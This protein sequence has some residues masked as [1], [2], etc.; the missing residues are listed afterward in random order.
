MLASK[1]IGVALNFDRAEKKFFEELNQ[2]YAFFFEDDLIVNKFYIE[3]LEQ[4][5]QFALEDERIAYVSAYGDHRA[6]LDT[7]KKRQSEVI[8]MGH[9]WGFS[10]TQRQWLRQKDILDGYL[11]IVSKRPYRARDH[12]AI[13]QYFNSLG[14]SSPGSSQDA[15]KDV[16]SLVLGTVKLNTVACF[17]KN[18]GAVGLHS[19]QQFYD[20]QGFGDTIMLESKP[21]LQKPN[22]DTI[23]QL[24]ATQRRHARVSTSNDFQKLAESLFGG[25]PYNNFSPT[26]KEPDLQ[27]WNG[28]H[29]AL[30]QA[31]YKQKPKIIVDVGVWKG[32]STINLARSQNEVRSDG[33]VIAVDTFLGAA[34]HWDIKRQDVYDS[35]KFKNGRPSIYE[36]FMSNVVLNRLQSQILPLS[37]TSENAAFILKRQGINPDLVHLDAAQEYD[38][39]MRDIKL[40]WDI[41]SPG[42]V[43]MG[44]DFAWT[45]VARA[46][47]HFSDQ[48]GHNFHV[49]G[50]KWWITKPK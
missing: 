1:N 32:Q 18:I 27:G 11:K 46:V 38:S 28:N 37:Q 47:V 24:I 19:N 30:T 35:L 48:T 36:T 41:L 50:P 2:K 5:T 21:R 42:G 22:S 39:V 6:S 9:K 45:G 44:D 16:A 31:V 33:I 43:L 25:D 7:Q 12:K 4:M 15:A 34:Q 13:S 20:S 29:G 14:Y 3:A 10:L 8:P 26:L 49:D 17:G 40:Y 23:D